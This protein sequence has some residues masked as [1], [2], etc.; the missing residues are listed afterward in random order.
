MRRRVDMLLY[1]TCAVLAAANALRPAPGV[2]RAGPRTTPRASTTARRA[3]P[4]D[5]FDPLEVRLDVTCLWCQCLGRELYRELTHNPPKAVPGFTTADLAAL[6]S[7]TSS[8]SALSVCWVAA[9]LWTRQFEAAD[10]DEGVKRTLATCALAAPPWLLFEV[11]VGAPAARD[12]G[13]VASALG[14]AATMS[15]VRLCR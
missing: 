10:A 2:S 11:L 6:G 4:D 14:L 1:L 8:A 7:V 12:A 9:G 13:V 3:R 15:V 5:S